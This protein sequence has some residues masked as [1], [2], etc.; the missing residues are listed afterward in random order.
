MPTMI[1][2]GHQ[3]AGVH[4]SLALQAELGALVDRGA[5]HVAGGDV[6][7]DVVARQAHALGALARA[8]AAEDDQADAQGHR[9][10]S[11]APAALGSYFRKPS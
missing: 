2:V 8:L 7:H 10:C 11:G 5:Q 1:V 6:G 9:R 3:L 4:D